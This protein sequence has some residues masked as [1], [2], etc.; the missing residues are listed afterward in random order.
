MQ[1][2]SVGAGDDDEFEDGE[3]KLELPDATEG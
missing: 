2:L 3:Q 1:C